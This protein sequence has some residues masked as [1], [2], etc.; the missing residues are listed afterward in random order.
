M[1]RTSN[2]HGG[3]NFWHSAVNLWQLTEIFK[4]FSWIIKDWPADCQRLKKKNP[5]LSK[6]DLPIVKDCLILILILMTRSPHLILHIHYCYRLYCI[7]LIYICDCYF[8]SSV[9]HKYPDYKWMVEHLSKFHE[10][11]HR[12]KACMSAVDLHCLNCWIILQ[13]GCTE[14]LVKNLWLNL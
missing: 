3:E 5:E 14:I 9:D 12:V 8:I 11:Y 10:K 6:I 7:F 13:S 1:R 4:S 2:E